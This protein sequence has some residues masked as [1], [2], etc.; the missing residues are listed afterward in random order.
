MMDIG[1]AKSIVSCQNS[2]GKFYNKG[3]CIT[4]KLYV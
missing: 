4:H 3:V 1:L 2:Y